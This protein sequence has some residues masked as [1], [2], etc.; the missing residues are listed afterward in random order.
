MAG[1]QNTGYTKSILQR[2]LLQIDYNFMNKKEVQRTSLQLF[3][4]HTF[5]NIVC[6]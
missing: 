1:G 2:N 6:F 5:K 4:I 3:F